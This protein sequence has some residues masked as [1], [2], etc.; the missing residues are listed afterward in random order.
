MRG[1]TARNGWVHEREERTS[2]GGRRHDTARVGPDGRLREFT[3]YK[4]RR[5][6]GYDEAFFQLQK[7]REILERNPDARGRGVI[8][9]SARLDLHVRTAMD[10][11]KHDFPGRFEEQRVT[12]EQARKA[13]AI[14]RELERTWESGQLELHDVERLREQERERQRERHRQL[15]QERAD[16]VRAQKEERERAARERAE[17]EAA[18]RTRALV[19]RAKEIQQRE[20]ELRKLMPGAPDDVR[21][22]LLAQSRLPSDPKRSRSEATERTMRAGRDTQQRDRDR[23]R[24]G[25]GRTD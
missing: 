19:Q 15:A 3:E 9:D 1:E 6:I 21:A 4:N 17:A 12:R 2:L 25:R 7:E 5:Y 11:L 8:R 23:G 22:V 18:E 13:E 16:R 24:D 20:R 14:G 10:R